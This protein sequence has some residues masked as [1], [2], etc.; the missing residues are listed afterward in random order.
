MS[1][2]QAGPTRLAPEGETPLNGLVTLDKGRL[3]LVYFDKQGAMQRIIFSNPETE[4]LM[5][6]LYDNRHFI[7]H[8]DERPINDNHNQ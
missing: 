5:T 1:N 4:V 2:R 8:P 6:F 7:F 3:V